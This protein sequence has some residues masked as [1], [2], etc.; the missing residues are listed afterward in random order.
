MEWLATMHRQSAPEGSQRPNQLNGFLNRRVFFS[1]PCSK[2]TKFTKWVNLL[3]LIFLN[4][5]C[6]LHH[7]FLLLSLTLPLSRRFFIFFCSP[8]DSIV[9]FYILWS[10]CFQFELF[11]T[12]LF[13]VYVKFANKNLALQSN[14]VDERQ[15]E[16]E[17]DRKWVKFEMKKNKCK[18]MCR[19]QFKRSNVKKCDRFKS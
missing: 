10:L 8:I 4:A 1:T 5:N 16:R 17:R 2:Y 11:T 19:H 3:A 12:D 7:F 18:T 9:Y 14:G 13:A 6:F 15:R